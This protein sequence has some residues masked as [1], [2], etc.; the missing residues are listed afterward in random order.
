[1][2]RACASESG[3]P[4]T[5]VG[6]AV[7]KQAPEEQIANMVAANDVADFGSLQ[8]VVF[9]NVLGVC[10]TGFIYQNYTKTIDFLS[11]P[12]L[13]FFLEKRTPNEYNSAIPSRCLGAAAARLQGRAA[14]QAVQMLIKRKLRDSSELL[15][16]RP[17][18]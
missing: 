11:L 2:V 6:L 10:H 12:F 15:L 13:Y 5:A 17:T 9:L 7:R 4:L 18:R 3:R 16:T 8:M 14:R 1:M